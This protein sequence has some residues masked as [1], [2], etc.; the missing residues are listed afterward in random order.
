MI[1]ALP[2]P[3]DLDP[4]HLSSRHF[5]RVRRGFEPTEV[6]AALGRSADALRTWQER[7]ERLVDVESTTSSS[8]LVESHELDEDR[9]TD[10]AG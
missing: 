4:V 6:N 3:P 9:I 5:T 1:D 2:D 7:D 8:R 10:R